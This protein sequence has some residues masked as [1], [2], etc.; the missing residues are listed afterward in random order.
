MNN[1]GVVIGSILIDNG[2]HPFLD[3]GFSGQ[4]VQP[5]PPMPAPSYGIAIAKNSNAIAGNDSTINNKAWV[6]P[7]ATGSKCPRPRLTGRRH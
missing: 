2:W 6:R 3:P 4:T 1:A 5:I 7:S